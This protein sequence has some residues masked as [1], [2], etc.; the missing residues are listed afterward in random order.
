MLNQS[1]E[2]VIVAAFL[3]DSSK[4]IVN[5]LSQRNISINILCFQIFS[6]G[7]EQLLSRSWAPRSGEIPS[8]QCC[9]G[10]R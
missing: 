8:K 1:H 2:I 10:V 7:G 6:I 3:D 5:Y 4:R 9:F